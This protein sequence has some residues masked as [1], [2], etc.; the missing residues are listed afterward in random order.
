MVIAAIFLMV[1]KPGLRAVDAART[2]LPR[3][4]W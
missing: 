1:T 2:L 3:D 4:K